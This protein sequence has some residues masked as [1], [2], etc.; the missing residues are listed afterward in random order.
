VHDQPRVRAAIGLAKMRLDGFCS[1]QAGD[2]EGWFISRREPFREPAV[3][4][5]AK[6]AK[7]GFV[8]AEILD[9]GNRVVPGF[10]RDECEPF[11]GDAVRHV[12]RWRTERFLG[13]AMGSDYKLRFWL[14]SAQLYS[15]LPQGLD[16]GQPDLARFPKRG[17]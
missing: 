15:Y 17:P 6:T 4:I 3:T 9:R 5:N 12:L 10:S 16:P 11:A 13:G 7:D 14:K 2:A 1:L 8:V